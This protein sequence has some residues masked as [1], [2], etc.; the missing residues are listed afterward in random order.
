[1]VGWSSRGLLRGTLASLAGLAAMSLYFR[2]LSSLSGNGGGDGEAD[3]SGNHKRA[4]DDIS[5]LEQRSR[6][7]EP[8]TETV[9]RLA[10]E[11]VT[12]DEPEDDRRATLGQVVHWGYGML[13]GALY[14]ALRDDDADGLDVGGG[15]G[16]GAALWLLGDE[17]AVPVL[18]LARGPTAH[19]AS[20]HAS[21]FGAHLVYGATTAAANRALSRVL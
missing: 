15:L 20:M 1:M 12:G 8:A 9:A 11:A 2:V 17:I 7:G 19:P 5:L 21:M 6:D 14:G 4:L 18:G 10:H 3:E 16:Y 13:V